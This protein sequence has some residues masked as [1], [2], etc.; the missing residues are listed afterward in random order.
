MPQK[1]PDGSL[2]FKMVYFGPELAGKGT[3]IRWIHDKERGIKTGKLT[4][5]RAGPDA[6][7]FDRMMAQ[8]G[9]SN[10]S[11]QVWSVVGKKSFESLQKAILGGVDGLIFVWDLTKK[12][13]KDNLAAINLLI[14]ILGK[15]LIGIPLVCMLNKADVEARVTKKDVEGIFNKAKLRNVEFIETVA[16]DGMNVKNAFTICA[17]SILSTY[18]KK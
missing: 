17:K 2:V 11:F 13:W 12:A 3:S 6:S 7:F 14:S 16:I 4:Q 9:K 18:I 10:V 15:K 5:V 8:I 1:L